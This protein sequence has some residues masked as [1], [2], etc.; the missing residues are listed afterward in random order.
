MCV[1]GS[2]SSVFTNDA[3][4][5]H[6]VQLLMPAHIAAASALLLPPPRAAAAS[7]AMPFSNRPRAQLMF[8]NSA[9]NRA[10]QSQIWY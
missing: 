1:A 4:Q 2:H 8:A 9:A 10:L 7:L 3:S 6:H 5:Y